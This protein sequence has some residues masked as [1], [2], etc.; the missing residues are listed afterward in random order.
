MLL[1][2]KGHPDNKKMKRVLFNGMKGIIMVSYQR[3]M[4]LTIAPRE[5]S[6]IIGS[7]AQVKA[8]SYKYLQSQ[9]T[10]KLFQLV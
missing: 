1:S 4:V 5:V 7:Q 9:A 8:L 10:S 3:G 2:F 6:Q